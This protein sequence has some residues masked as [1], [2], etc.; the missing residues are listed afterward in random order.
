MSIRCRSADTKTTALAARNSASTS[1]APAPTAARSSWYSLM[2]IENG[3]TPISAKRLTS[4]AMP[5]K[6]STRSAP[7]I[8]RMSWLPKRWP[9]RPTAK[10]A[11]DLQTEWFSVWNSAA[12]A[13]NGPRP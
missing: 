12:N 13:P 9:S 11:S 6:L 3:A 10:N 1:Q 7:E 2:K 5:H 8:A 4:S